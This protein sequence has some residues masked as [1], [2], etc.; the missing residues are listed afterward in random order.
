MHNLKKRN[1]NFAHKIF[2]LY[3]NLYL[4]AFNLVFVP[5]VRCLY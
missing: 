2:E 4:M 1:I 5:L 3:I